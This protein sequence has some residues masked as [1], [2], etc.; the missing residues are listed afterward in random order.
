MTRRRRRAG[1]PVLLLP[2]VLALLWVGGEGLRLR[3]RPGVMA[4][5]TVRDHDRR[6]DGPPAQ[7]PSPPAIA[8]AR[9]AATPLHLQDQ[10]RFFGRLAAVV[11][12]AQQ[13]RLARAYATLDTVR[14]DAF[15]PQ[16]MGQ[17]AA[18]EQELEDHLQR[19]C[20]D[21]ERLVQDGQAPQVSRR[22]RELLEPVHARV[23]Y[24][25]RAL[26]RRQ[27]WPCL[28]AHDLPADPPA[29]L[30]AAISPISAG[31]HVRVTV[32]DAWVDGAA[33]ATSAAADV[34]SVRVERSDG[35]LFPAIA[36]AAV[37][38]VAPTPAELLSQLGAA[39]RSRE[40]HLA[41]A[42]LACCVARDVVLDA[43][44]AAALASWFKCD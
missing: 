39:L 18:L 37:A 34:V 44:S 9:P 35:V 13:G 4:D 24:V 22:V 3:S 2:L 38:F 31:R 16:A 21:V 28:D 10:D 11:A 5:P 27:R 30:S 29:A 23:H 33:S 41:R 19:A 42:W 32:Q 36:R 40:S 25:L 12:D 26:C 43:A 7:T 14:A 6:P 17:I 20:A 15:A 1:T 8:P